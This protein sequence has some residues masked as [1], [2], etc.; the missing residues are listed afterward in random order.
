MN[1]VSVS[2]DFETECGKYYYSLKKEP[3][4]KKLKKNQYLIIRDDPTHCSG[5]HVP[6]VLIDSDYEWDFTIPVIIEDPDLCE[7]PTM[8]TVTCFF[9]YYE[10]GEE[11]AY[12]CER[13]FK[14]TMPK[15]LRSFDK[16]FY[17][18]QDFKRN[19]PGANGLDMD[20]HNFPK[21]IL[22]S[23]TITFCI[24][25]FEHMNFWGPFQI[26][27]RSRYGIKGMDIKTIVI[28]HMIYLTLTNIG[29][30]EIEF[31]SP[32]CQIILPEFYQNSLNGLA[33]LVVTE[34]R[35]EKK[36]E[37]TPSY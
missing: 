36:I 28:D 17:Y 11:D 23:T 2:F 6:T 13:F 16:K 9:C 22:N 5:F 33:T 1:F 26:I 20:F 8:L 14:Q 18:I 19:S 21:Q 35:K 29:P 15:N 31:E 24:G 3:E 30:D 32:F 12:T 10:V 25:R 27:P 7:E 4:T 37:I 34:P